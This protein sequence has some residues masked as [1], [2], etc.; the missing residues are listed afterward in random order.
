M[1]DPGYS[2]R[3][4]R[5]RG[6]EMALM[7]I[8]VVAF[9]EVGAILVGI[10]RSEPLPAAAMVPAQPAPVA[11]EPFPPV[12]PIAAPPVPEAAVVESPVAPSVPPNMP[13]SIGRG[14][15]TLPD[16]VV[17]EIPA[18]PVPEAAPLAAVEPAKP[19]GPVWVGPGGVVG[20]GATEA[21]PSVPGEMRPVDPQ[22]LTQELQ[23]AAPTSPLEDGI[24]ERLLVAGAELRGT[25]NNQGALKN[26]REVEGEL[27][28]H[29]RVLSEIAATL[30]SLGLSEK[31]AAYWQR[32]E[33]LGEAG[34]GP[35][36]AIAGLALHGET[37]APPPAPVS[38]V[39]AAVMAPGQY[40]R[41]GE[42]KVEEQ[43][44]GS[45]G[46]RVTLSITIDADPASQ[47]VADD[48][49]MTVPFYDRLAGGEIRPTTA[50][51][52]YDHPSTPYDWSTGSET[53]V[54]TYLQPAF[55][56]EQKREIGE[57]SFYGYAIELYYRED[58]QDKV[59]KPD[60]IAALRLE[61][62]AL[63]SRKPLPAGPENALF[64]TP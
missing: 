46:Q 37:V 53:I 10:Y 3:P 36:F 30:G 22:R 27:P 49:F 13:S 24:L 12:A 15:P 64:P 2:E 28:D 42:V 55:T 6:F 18:G 29:P 61:A 14:T 52:S 33:A 16:P 50:E 58:L 43:T 20:D 8:G 21:A 47:I 38:P 60:D 9:I 59:A 40:L 39:A 32:V 44:R 25:G 19:E 63:D 1:T 11:V 48:I 51:T 62:G 54:V 23:A 26:F 7:V 34:G 5:G 41:I 17:A 56:E 57:R 4:A 35:W 31:S 45:E